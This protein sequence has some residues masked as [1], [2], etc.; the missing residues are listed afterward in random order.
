MLQLVLPSFTAYEIALIG[1]ILGAIYSLLLP[2]YLKV[3]SNQLTWSEF[4]VGYLINFVITIITGVAF[5]LLVFAVWVI[6]EGSQIVVFIT[7]FF[8]A[9][10]LD[11]AALKRLLKAIGAYEAI[12]NRLNK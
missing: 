3:R 5:S 12:Y 9:A 11:E 6:P 8:I 2:F 10:G 4:N 7:A 1:W